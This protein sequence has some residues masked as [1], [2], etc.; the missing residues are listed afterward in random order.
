MHLDSKQQGSAA[1]RGGCMQV[2]KHK[3]HAEWA[4]KKYAELE[5]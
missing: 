3:E 2:R 5:R 1:T 4:E